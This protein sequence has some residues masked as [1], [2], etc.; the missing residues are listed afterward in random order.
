V[1]PSCLPLHM[2]TPRASPFICAPLVP[3]PSYVHP[4]CLPPSHPSHPLSHA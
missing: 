2:C 1:H 4:S 3:P